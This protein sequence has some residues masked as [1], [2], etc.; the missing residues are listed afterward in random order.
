MRRELARLLHRIEYGVAPEE[1]KAAL[2]ALCVREGIFS[3]YLTDFINE[4]CVHDARVHAEL[5]EL[6]ENM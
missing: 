1:S 2:R 5:R 6:F 3:E 4:V